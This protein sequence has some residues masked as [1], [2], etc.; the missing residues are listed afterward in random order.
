MSIYDNLPVKVSTSGKIRTIEEDIYGVDPTNPAVIRPYELGV[1]LQDIVQDFV[2]GV[3]IPL[4]EKGVAGGVATLDGTG[5]IPASQVPANPGSYLPLDG[6]EPMEGNMNMD[7]YTIG[8]VGTVVTDDLYVQW[9]D[10]P[11]RVIIINQNIAMNSHKIT[12]VEKGT[13]INDAA[14]IS[15]ISDHDLSQFAHADL[16]NLVAALQGT[17]NYAGRISLNTAQVTGTTLNLRIQELKGR[18]PLNGDVIVDNENG[19]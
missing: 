9:I 15:N 6:S 11:G 2:P 12:N 19:E 1:P 7:G 10:S 4:T 17:Y 16:R 13:A 18:G 5:K 3:Y 8:N 14:T